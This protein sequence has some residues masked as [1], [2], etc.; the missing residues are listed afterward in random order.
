MNKN[1]NTTP[2]H[3][4]KVSCELRCSYSS[5]C[6]KFRGLSPLWL[7]LVI[8]LSMVGCIEFRFRNA[9]SLLI[10]QIISL[11]CSFFLFLSWLSS[12]LHNHLFN[13]PQLELNDI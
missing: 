2:L 12:G 4:Y 10:G 9:E 13:F 7:N 3:S 8:P 6:V 1:G 5:K 11:F